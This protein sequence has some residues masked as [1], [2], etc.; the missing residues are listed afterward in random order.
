MGERAVVR[1][2]RAAVFSAVCVSLAAA[3]HSYAAHTW[4][5]A[6]GVVIGLAVVFVFARIAAARERGVG[7]IAALLLGGQAGLHV[8][9]GATMPQPPMPGMAS[10]TGMRHTHVLAAHAMPPESA[11]MIGGHLVAALLV[12]W[13][14]RCGEAALFRLVRTAVRRVYRRWLPVCGPVPDLRIP[15]CCG[16]SY[17]LL[18]DGGWAIR[19][20]VVRRGPPRVAVTI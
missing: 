19:F 15:S 10:M 12:A 20:A 1:T 2:G 9:F 8:L 11:A 3:A 17:E 4:V 13:W 14:L 16:G 6:R 5:P 7:A 18:P